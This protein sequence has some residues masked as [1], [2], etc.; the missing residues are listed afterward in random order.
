M[1]R[2]LIIGGTGQ[3]GVPLVK[4][5]RTEGF[6]VSAP[7]RR[8]FDILSF[9][10]SRLGTSEESFLHEFE[11]DVVINCAAVH[12]AK[13]CER[14]PDTAS[15]T[16]DCAVAWLHNTISKYIQLIHISTDQV[17]RAPPG[18]QN[19]ESE[20]FWYDTYSK[21]KGLGELHLLR[22]PNRTIIRVSGLYG[23]SPCRGKPRPNFVEQMVSLFESSVESSVFTNVG[24]S[25][26]YTVD[27]AE[28][29]CSMLK[30]DGLPNIVHLA[31]EDL[32]GSYSWLDFARDIG[33]TF[34]DTT[35]TEWVLRGDFHKGPSTG[36]V[37]MTT[38]YKWKLPPVLDSL[39]RY[40]VEREQ[41]KQ[42][43][44]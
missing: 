1:K 15:Q 8:E 25:P 13:F 4:C 3:L 44:C 16:N 38:K 35:F 12:D 5:L 33:N 27:I 9:W 26:G 10:Y 17:L 22:Q 40:K 29:I 31:P 28:Q 30:E 42:G 21:T 2:V 7:S 18:L 43:V 24:C 39:K 11:P 41:V 36:L 34:L 6:E 14:H 19:E 23:T 37:N 20:T 32:N